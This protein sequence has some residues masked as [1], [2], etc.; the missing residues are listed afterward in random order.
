M[1]NDYK[2]D[3]LLNVF[4]VATVLALI[5]VISKF[6][7]AY[8]FPFV[9]GACVAF[10]VQKP[11]LYLS[12]RFHI[13]KKI[14]AVM[15]TVL[16]CF[17]VLV[18]VF[19]GTWAIGNRLTGYISKAPEY[20]RGFQKTV[21]GIEKSITDNIQ[22]L[23]AGQRSAI[24]TA[25]SKTINSFVTL[26]TGFISDTAANI[27]KGLP[28]FLVSSIVTVVASCYLAKDF[29]RLKRF[30]AGLMKPQK[31]KILSSIKN[32][33]VKNSIK[34]I[35]GYGIISVITFL[36]L[37]LAFWVLGIKNAV[38]TAMLISLVDALPV[39]GVGTVIIPWAIIELLKNNFILGF[40]LVITYGVIA[41][42]RNFIEPKIIG[43]QMGINPI[44]TLF[45]MFLG[46]KIAGIFGMILFPL[47]LT[48][49]IDYYKNENISDGD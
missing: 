11:A 12:E 45:S 15:L 34:F 7:L 3:F 39:L 17:F 35:K 23:T 19:L 41:V 30:A 18:A 10:V 43:N 49:M 16:V 6:L 37:S 31:V 8:I 20:I 28:G 13:N 22:S 21:D 5:V 32:V 2:K 24:E 4:Y 48:V 25:F 38:L 1:T 44:F 14:F 26:A 42:V 40:G 46:L 9:I 36:E 27:I 33:F 47:T 29:D